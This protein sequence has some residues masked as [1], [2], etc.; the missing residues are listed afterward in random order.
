MW[1][2]DN[3]Y[4]TVT[5]YSKGTEKARSDKM[6]GSCMGLFPFGKL[7]KNGEAGPLEWSIFGF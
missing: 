7:G 2:Q 1:K 4:K 3:Q 5:V 6:K